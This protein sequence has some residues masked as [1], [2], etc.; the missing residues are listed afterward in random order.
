MNSNYSKNNNVC[1]LHLKPLCLH[2]PHTHYGTSLKSVLSY[3][4][5]HIFQVNTLHSPVV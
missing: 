5:C 2:S 3:A 1:D 4:D